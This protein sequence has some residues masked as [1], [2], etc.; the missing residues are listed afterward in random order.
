VFACSWL[1]LKA[2]LA[3]TEVDWQFRAQI[4]SSQAREARGEL[5]L[6]EKLE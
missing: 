2:G 5:L 1:A 3:L 4:L 6:V